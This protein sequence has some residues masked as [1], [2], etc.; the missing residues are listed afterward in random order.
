MISGDFVIVMGFLFRKNSFVDTRICYFRNCTRILVVKAHVSLQNSTFRSEFKI[1]NE[2][3]RENLR[4]RNMFWPL[5][6]TREIILYFVGLG[7][8]CKWISTR[9]VGVDTA[10]ADQKEISKDPKP[11]YL[12]S[13]G[14]TIYF[15]SFVHLSKHKSSANFHQTFL[16]LQ[17][18]MSFL[19]RVRPRCHR[20]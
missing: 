16:F 2:V 11:N 5:R 1:E 10:K 8:R 3:L 14:D 17:H 12:S 18:N 13:A 19:A 20:F 15:Q 4:N 7:K 6:L 9:K